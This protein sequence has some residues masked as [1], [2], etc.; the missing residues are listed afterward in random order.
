MNKEEWKKQYRVFRAAVSSIDRSEVQKGLSKDEA[1]AV[2][3][4]F[5]S[6]IYEK[7]PKSIYDAVSSSSGKV[8]NSV[9]WGIKTRSAMQCNV[10]RLRNSYPRVDVRNHGCH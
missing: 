9:D 2:W 4:L 10:E 5:W 6:G 1:D 3:D 7:M 8:Y